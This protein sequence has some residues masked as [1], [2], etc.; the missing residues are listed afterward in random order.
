[1]DATEIK[2]IKDQIAYET[3]RSDAPEGY[4]AFP[5]LPG[6][7]YTDDAFF[8]LEKDHLWRKTWM[9][10]AHMDEI[11]EPGCHKLW[12]R[13]GQPIIIV[14]D[15]KG[16]VNA[17]YNTCRH[18]GAPVVTEEFGKGSRLVCGY[19]GWNFSLEGELVS[20]RDKR[21]FPELD[22]SCRGLHSIRCERFGNMVFVNFDL[23]APSLLE[24]LGPVAAQ[25]EEFQFENSRL[26]HRYTID[27]QCNWKIAMEANMEVYHVKSIHPETVDVLL[28]YKGNVNTLYPRGHGR[29]I[30]PSRPD[31]DKTGILAPPSDTRPSM[32]TVGEIGKT[33]TQSYNIVPNWVSPLSDKG[34]PVLLFWPTSINTTTFEV[35]WFGADWG[36]GEKPSE[37][38][39]YIENFHGVLLEDTQF[40]DWIQKSVESYAFD[41]VP[42]S[43]QEARIYHWHQQVDQVIGVENIPEDL[44]V[45]PVITEKW[46][47][48]ND[49]EERL[50]QYHQAAAE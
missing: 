11:Q 42:L 20:I 37:W 27:L 3:A 4:P 32:D 38:E 40:G 6:K 36:E 26:V 45:E 39:G 23:E 22:F 41:G 34:F 24:Y 17:F 48:P 9:L 28:D 7:R 47:D 50:R 46:L 15:K 14:H 5:D 44:R 43:Y 21:D 19:H 30:A 16:N 29:M 31:R 1:M 10:A 33:C 12:E 13:A 8:E 25:W 18:R 35:W 49:T 2:D